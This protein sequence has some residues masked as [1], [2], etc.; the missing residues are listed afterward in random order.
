MRQ[1]SGTLLVA[2]LLCATG[3][4]T[5]MKRGDSAVADK[6]APGEQI[7]TTAAQLVTYLNDCSGRLNSVTSS[8]EMDCKAKGESF[9]LEGAMVCEKPRNLRLRGSLIG[10]AECDIGSNKDEFWYWIKHDNPPLLYHCSYDAMSQGNVRLPFPF[11]PDVVMAALGM[12]E[13][14]SDPNRYEVKVLPKTVELSEKSVSAQ[15]QEVRKVTVFSRTKVELADLRK[16]RPQVLE[17][18]ISDTRGQ[19]ICKATVERVSVEGGVIVPRRIRVSW[20]A[21]QMEL[22]LTLKTVDVNSRPSPEAF[23]RTRLP[24]RSFDLARRAEDGQ[25]T[26][27]QRVRGSL[28]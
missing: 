18:K 3:C 12:A 4:S 25:P 24:Y 11:Q 28:R 5:W 17:F 8:L 23:D 27:I 7:P 2:T 21:S 14:N 13:F 1:L 22:A 10:Q 6:S 9:G 19:D 26:S 15:G 16:G 20:P